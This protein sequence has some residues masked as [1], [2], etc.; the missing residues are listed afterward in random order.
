MIKHIFTG[1]LNAAIDSNP[2]FP[3]KER[4]FLRAQ[5]ARITHG[6]VMI[7][8]GLLEIDEETQK[9]KYTEEFA[10]PGTE[11]LKSLEVWGHAHSIIL[12]VGRTT[13]IAPQGKTDEEK[14]EYLALVGEKDPA[15]DRYRGLNEDG[16]MPGL[17][18]AWLSKL[19]GDQQPY[20]QMPPKEGTA[21]YAV[22]VLKSL[23]WPGALTAS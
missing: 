4:H 2:P 18:T 10:I 1:N 20:N 12:G 14:D 13:H 3:G 9:E 8:K 21:S 7:P 16:P 15:V 23:R 6:A 11:E 22:N 17:E 19:V 5:I